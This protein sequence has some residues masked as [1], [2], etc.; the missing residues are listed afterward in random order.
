MSSPHAPGGPM[1]PA[2]S[3]PGPTGPGD[4]REPGATG[5]RVTRDEVRDLARIRRS[6]TDRKVAGVAGG[7]A[8]HLDIDPLLLRVAF[9]ILT[10][11]GGGGLVL[12]GVAWLILPEEDTDRAVIRLEDGVRSVA[13]I[14]AGVIAAASILGDAFGGQG[15]PWP[16]IVLGGIL[17]AIFV[18][19]D[20]I[21]PGGPTHPWLGGPPH[22]PDAEGVGPAGG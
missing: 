3:E 16:V 17:V 2:D 20:A 21:K 7:L 9:V 6:R 18:A 4:G 12:Y 5:P 8:R 13:L 10:F 22:A 11:F 1:G 19:K 15:F 14:I